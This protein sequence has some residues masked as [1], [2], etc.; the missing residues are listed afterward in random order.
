M[1]KRGFPRRM[2]FRAFVGV[3]V[4]EA[5]AITALLSGLAATRADLK[6]V[7]PEN[8]H[9]TLSF[10]GQVP[11]E[12]AGPLSRALDA[13]VHGQPAFR[14]QLQGV[15]AFP[16]ASRPRVVWAGVA[17]P[18]PLVALATRVR[19][20]LAA[21]G[22]AG[23]DKEFRAHLTLARTRSPRGV[24]ALVGFLREHA[25]DPLPEIDVR[26]V[27]LYRSLLGPSGPTYETVHA[28]Q[29]EA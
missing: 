5:P 27:R 18:A 22:H 13:A 26:D 2:S 14:A 16:S 9:M 8:L 3:P 21:A 1:A 6:V 20:A 4:Q 17:E 10:L 7:A 28:A 19:E 29:L 12:A 24:D 25:R 23:D 11:D 15:G